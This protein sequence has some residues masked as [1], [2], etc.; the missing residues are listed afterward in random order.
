MW[1]KRNCFSFFEK[2]P[3]IDMINNTTTTD[4]IQYKTEQLRSLI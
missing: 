2:K 3:M 1:G 4:N